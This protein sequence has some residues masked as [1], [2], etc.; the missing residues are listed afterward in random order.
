MFSDGLIEQ[1]DPR[2]CLF[3]IARVIEALT[4]SA[5]P[6]EDVRALSEAVRT[7]AQ[8]DRLADD[9]TVASIERLA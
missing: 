9:Y 7:F 1:P 8:T 4:P 5:S 3:G 6:L 2:G